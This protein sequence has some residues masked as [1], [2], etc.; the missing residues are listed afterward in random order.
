MHVYWQLHLLHNQSDDLLQQVIGHADK[1][2]M[3][4]GVCFSNVAD[5]CQA[6]T[7]NEVGQDVWLYVN[8]YMRNALRFSLVQ[9]AEF[10]FSSKILNYSY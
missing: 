3:T 1:L 9:G 5:F 2:C 8:L 7:Q 10:N 4:I 6:V